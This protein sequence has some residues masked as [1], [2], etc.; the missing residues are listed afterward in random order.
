M[1]DTAITQEQFALLMEKMDRVESHIAE[2]QRR[3]QEME[4]LQR[5]L[6]PIGNHMV[7]LAIDELAEIGSDFQSEDLFFLLKRVLRDT[8]L[9]SKLLDQ[10]E[11]AMEL[12]EDMQILGKQI[13]NQGVLEL[14]R[15]ER[16]GYFTFAQEGWKIVE[17]VVTEFSEED[18][19]ALADNVVVILKTVRNM[20]Q[21]E[22]M[23]IANQSVDAIREIPAED[24]NISAFKLVKEMG[25]PQVRRGMSRMLNLLKVMGETPT[26]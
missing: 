22:I 20:T 19:R 15:L 10:L 23:A 3:Q 8:H 12:S 16:Q 9:L 21:P 26:Q 6:I 7:K 2:Q 25:S 18:V 24:E 5:D 17:R 11:N 13:F 1:T 14:D 4:E